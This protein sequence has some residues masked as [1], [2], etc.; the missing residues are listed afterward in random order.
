MHVYHPVN[1]V[2]QKHNHFSSPRI[3]PDRDATKFFATIKGNIFII[4]DF[5]KDRSQDFYFVLPFVDSMVTKCSS[6]DKG[7]LSNR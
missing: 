5:T 7:V 3:E 4:D 2:L 1:Y 6:F